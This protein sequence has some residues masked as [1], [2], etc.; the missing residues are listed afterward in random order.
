MKREDAKVSQVSAQQAADWCFAKLEMREG[1]G[2]FGKDHE[3][4][5]HEREALHVVHSIA[6]CEVA[7]LA[8]IVGR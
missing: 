3:H 6:L 8:S 1:A 7:R 4:S 2:G 5:E